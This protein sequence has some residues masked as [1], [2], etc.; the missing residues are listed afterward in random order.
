MT[1]EETVHP[2]GDLI[3]VKSSYSDNEG[4]ECVEVA[5]HRSSHSDAEGNNCVEVG[6]R[7][8]SHSDNAGGNCLE[9]ADAA[10]VVHIRDS[11]APEGPT[12]TV[13]HKGWAAFLQYA[14]KG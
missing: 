10:A 6:W 5:W 1:A 8:S 11:K 9:V 3:W 13:P 12:L 2:Q 7:K 14:T 4:G